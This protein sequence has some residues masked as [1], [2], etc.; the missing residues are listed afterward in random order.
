M[1]FVGQGAVKR[2]AL[3]Q[4]QETGLVLTFLQD[5]MISGF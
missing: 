4:L 2:G 5:A 1:Q 3:L